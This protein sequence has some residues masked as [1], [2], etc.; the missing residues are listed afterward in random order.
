MHLFS[1]HKCVHLALI[2]TYINILF[3][4]S[5]KQ[6]TKCFILVIYLKKKIL[7]RFKNFVI[8]NIFQLIVSVHAFKIN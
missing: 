1:I 5:F 6:Y 7:K 2:H 3:F 4:N 8:W